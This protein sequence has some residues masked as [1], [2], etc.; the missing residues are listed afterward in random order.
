MLFTPS[1]VSHLPQLSRY[2]RQWPVEMGLSLCVSFVH[3]VCHQ[4]LLSCCRP[5]QMSTDAVQNFCILHVSFAPVSSFVF[6][7]L[8]I[9][10]QVDTAVA[11]ITDIGRQSLHHIK[12]SLYQLPTSPNASRCC[13]LFLHSANCRCSL[14]TFSQLSLLSRYSQQWPVET[15]L[16]SVGVHCSC[17]L[18]SVTALSLPTSPNANRCCSKCLHSA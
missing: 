14:D 16:V 12:C 8:L 15:G 13:S 18:P 4:S 10:V 5:H 7:V 1:A 3:A 2:S 6:T 9:T 17:S 11:S